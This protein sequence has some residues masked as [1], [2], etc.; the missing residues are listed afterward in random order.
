MNKRMEGGR[1]G[2]N[3][4]RKGDEGDVWIDGELRNIWHDSHKLIWLI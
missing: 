4:D 3:G 2:G 1:K